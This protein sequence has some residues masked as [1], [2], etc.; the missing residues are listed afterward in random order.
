ML[1]V[2][3]LLSVEMFEI[4]VDGIIIIQQSSTTI[5]GSTLSAQHRDLAYG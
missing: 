1:G 4:S 2:K 3:M 5:H